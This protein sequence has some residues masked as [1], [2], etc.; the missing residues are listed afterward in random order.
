MSKI[1]DAIFENG[2][3]KPIQ[4]V[5]VKEHQKVAIKIIFSDE[6][7][8]RFSK[9]ISKIH[10]KSIQY[11]SRDIEDDITKAIEEVREGKNGD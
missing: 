5:Q 1:I 4:D 9:I 7:Q 11:S 10:Q 2:V 3:F 8:S 6:W